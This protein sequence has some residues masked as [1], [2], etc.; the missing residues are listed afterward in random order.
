MHT[1]SVKKTMKERMTKSEARTTT[2]W[3]GGD[4]A[5]VSLWISDSIP[6]NLQHHLGDVTSD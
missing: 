2:G 4:G 1:I 6:V 3:E 5:P